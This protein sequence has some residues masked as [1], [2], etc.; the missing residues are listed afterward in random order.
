M[1]EY[2]NQL[3]LV[4]NSLESEHRDWETVRARL[5]TRIERE[6]LKIRSRDLEILQLKLSKEQET[7]ALSTQ[8]VTIRN[9]LEAENRSLREQLQQFSEA[10]LGNH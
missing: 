3:V 1:C 10:K 8:L 2:K 6:K 9:Q 5:E 7:A 4:K